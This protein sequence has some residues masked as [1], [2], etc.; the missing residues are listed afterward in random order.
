MFNDSSR[1]TRPI[2]GGHQP[3]S[4]SLKGIRKPERVKAKPATLPNCKEPPLTRLEAQ[5]AR[6][7]RCLCAQEECKHQAR[8][9]LPRC[10]MNLVNEEKPGSRR[11]QLSSTREAANCDGAT[12]GPQCWPAMWDGVSAPTLSIHP[13]GSSKQASCILKREGRSRS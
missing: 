6:F 9:T 5:R 8:H 13:R 7:N 11:R 12:Q 10:T 2:V 4:I 3:P 1:A